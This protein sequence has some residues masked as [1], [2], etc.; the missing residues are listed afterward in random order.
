MTVTQEHR[1][2]GRTNESL[3]YPVSTQHLFIA[4]ALIGPLAQNPRPGPKLYGHIQH[5]I[6]KVM[7]SAAAEVPAKHEIVKG[8]G[9][10]CD[11]DNR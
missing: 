6:I 4:T 3:S 2:F 8:G 1:R 7:D 10:W 11:V 9:C 5:E